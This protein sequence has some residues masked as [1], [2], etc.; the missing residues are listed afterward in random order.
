MC[1][2]V[3]VFVCACLSC[4]CF[5]YRYTKSRCVCVWVGKGVGCVYVCACVCMEREKREA[6]A[7]ALRDSFLRSC[8]LHPL[9]P[10]PHSHILIPNPYFHILLPTSYS[11]NL[12]P[13]FSVVLCPP[14]SAHT[15]LPMVPVTRNGCNFDFWLGSCWPSWRPTNS[16]RRCR[17]WASEWWTQMCCS[18]WLLVFSSNALLLT[19]F[20]K[21]TV[22]RLL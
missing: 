13:A 10:I 9:L 18:R 5:L 15:P 17:G 19:P 4:V 3:C 22:H 7:V 20:V 16:L 14:F 12:T 2:C 11:R 8:R 21:S 6:D 1:V